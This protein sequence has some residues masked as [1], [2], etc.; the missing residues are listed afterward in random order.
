M[1]WQTEYSF[2]TSYFQLCTWFPYWS[3]SNVSLGGLLSGFKHVFEINR[4]L[5]STDFWVILLLHF[6][7]SGPILKRTF[8]ALWYVLYIFKH[9]YLQLFSYLQAVWMIPHDLNNCN[10]SFPYCKK[11]FVFRHLHLQ[12]ILNCKGFW[13]LIKLKLVPVMKVTC[14]QIL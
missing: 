2:S 11:E 4:L 5:V 8:S 10:C 14:F 7:F 9:L 12:V 13:M 1:F 3:P 6:Q